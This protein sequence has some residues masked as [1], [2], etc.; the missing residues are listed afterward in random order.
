MLSVAVI[1]AAMWSAAP[2]SAR[3]LFPPNVSISNAGG[4]QPGG[5]YTST[6]TRSAGRNQCVTIHGDGIQS[7][8]DGLAHSFGEPA[9]ITFPL[10]LKPKRLSIHAAQGIEPLGP[11]TAPQAL[12]YDLW[13]RDE[14]GRREWVARIHPEVIGD[15]YIDVSATWSDGRRCGGPG[16]ASYTFHLK[17]P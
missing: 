1:A 5:L 4:S 14:D 2:A 3:P 6:W 11:L 16:S 7:W 13:K 8:S 12:P 10:S 15:M 9:D 17:N